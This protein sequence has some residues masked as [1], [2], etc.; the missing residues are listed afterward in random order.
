M[1]DLISDLGYRQFRTSTL[2]VSLIVVKVSM[3]VMD[4]TFVDQNHQA[5]TY[6]DR[7]LRGAKPTDPSGAGAD[8]I[9]TDYQSQNGQSHR[10]IHPASD[11]ARAD[12][13]GD[14]RFWHKADIR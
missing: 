1:G 3:G 11:L 10:P 6:V 2:A 4:R 5:A 12:E 14:V 13:A 9:S 8:Q 7:I